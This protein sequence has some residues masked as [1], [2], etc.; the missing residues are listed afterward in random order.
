M[1]RLIWTIH[2]NFSNFMTKVKP[3]LASRLGG[4][5]TKASK[6]IDDAPNGSQSGSR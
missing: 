4:G 3:L 6:D 1:I 5:Y 2:L